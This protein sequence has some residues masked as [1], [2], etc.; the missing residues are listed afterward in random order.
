MKTAKITET[1]LIHTPWEVVG[2]GLSPDTFTVEEMFDGKDVDVETLTLDDI[3]STLGA[4]DAY[5][6]ENEEL[7]YYT[8]TDLIDD[9]P[10]W[11]D[12]LGVDSDLD[13]YD[14]NCLEHVLVSDD[15][16]GFKIE[17][18]GRMWDIQDRVKRC[19]N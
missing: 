3:R 15:G 9:L 13:N 19:L 6:I 5:I 14:M 7:T 17:I 1:T 8:R 4:P 12:W 2:R 16:W 11:L 18:E 10:K